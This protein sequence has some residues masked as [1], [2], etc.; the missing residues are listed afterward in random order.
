MKKA[1]LALALLLTPFALKAFDTEPDPNLEGTDRPPRVYIDRHDRFRD[2][3][4]QEN[5]DSDYDRRPHPG[6]YRGNNS[7]HPVFDQIRVQIIHIVHHGPN[8]IQSLQL[9]TMELVSGQKAMLKVND[10][11]YRVYATVKPTGKVDVDLAY[12]KRGNFAVQSTLLTQKTVTLTPKKSGAIV[13][14]NEE[15]RIIADVGSR[16]DNQ[17]FHFQQHNRYTEGAFRSSYHRSLDD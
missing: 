2:D 14:G 13:F 1:L 17:W 6:G 12:L 8:S 11:R 16:E 3:A 5:F 7:Y 9:P 15:F 10:R 4:A